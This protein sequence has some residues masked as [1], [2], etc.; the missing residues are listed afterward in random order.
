VAAL[1]RVV[2]V[3]GDPPG[4]DQWVT[5][6]G[7]FQPSP[8]DPPQLLVSSLTLTAAPDDPYE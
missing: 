3:S 2:G 8:G 5:V 4:R 7:S 1:V 6:T